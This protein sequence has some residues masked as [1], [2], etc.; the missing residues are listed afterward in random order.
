VC[1]DLLGDN[2]ERKMRITHEE[3]D[4]EKANEGGEKENSIKN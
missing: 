2:R 4:E 3:G 1:S